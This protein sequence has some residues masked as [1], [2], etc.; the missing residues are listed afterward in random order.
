M[1]DSLA[2]KMVSEEREP[3]RHAALHGESRRLRETFQ[4]S[5]SRGFIEKNS[6]SGW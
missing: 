4:S 2:Q 3:L 5:V 6:C 1:S